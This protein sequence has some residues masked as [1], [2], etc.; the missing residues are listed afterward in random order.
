MA[1]LWNLLSSQSLLVRFLRLRNWY[2]SNKNGEP[3][4]FPSYH[5]IREGAKR[6][7]RWNGPRLCSVEVRSGRNRNS[8]S[9]FFLLPWRGNDVPW[10]SA[11]MSFFQQVTSCKHRGCKWVHIE[12]H[13]VYRMFLSE[14]FVGLARHGI[15][16]IF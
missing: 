4:F 13:L 10:L 6:V 12:V 15:V 7:I 14:Y 2:W 9:L 16:I 3:F 8:P 1:E 5:P 11:K